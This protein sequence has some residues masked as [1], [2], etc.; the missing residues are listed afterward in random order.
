MK[1]PPEKS[2]VISK[3]EPP[4]ETVAASALLATFK[5]AR[6]INDALNVQ[7]IVR[8]EAGNRIAVQICKRIAARRWHPT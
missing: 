8:A 6:P 3:L 2:P 7:P 1:S 5:A 4:T